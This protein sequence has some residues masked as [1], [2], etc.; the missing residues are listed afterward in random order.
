MT[1]GWGIFAPFVVIIGQS[2]GLS[3]KDAGFAWG[4]YSLLTG[5][6][7]LVMGKFEDGA[8]RHGLMSFIGIC[9]LVLGS[10]AGYTLNS[11]YPA[12]ALYALGFGIAMPALKCYIANHKYAVMKQPNGHGWTVATCYL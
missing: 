2:Q 4:F 1:F 12:L 9:L 10:V 5:I 11:M 8:Q 7:M 6:I 3:V